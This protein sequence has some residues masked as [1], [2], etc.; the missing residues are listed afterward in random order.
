MLPLKHMGHRRTWE[1]LDVDVD[2][3]EPFSREDR[4]YLNFETLTRKFRG[5]VSIQK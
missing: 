1:K 5:K 4:I 2:D 3:G